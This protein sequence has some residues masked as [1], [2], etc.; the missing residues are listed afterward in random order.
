MEYRFNIN[1]VERKFWYNDIPHRDGGEGTMEELI[2]GKPSTNENPA[3]YINCYRDENKDLY[4]VTS[5]GIK[6]M[7]K[8]AITLT[9]E[10]FLQKAYEDTDNVLIMDEMMR[11]MQKY[12]VGCIRFRMNNNPLEYSGWS[13]DE[14]GRGVQKFFT[15]GCGHKGRGINYKPEWIEYEARAEFNRMPEDNYKLRLYATQN[16]KEHRTYD[17]YTMD[18]NRM[19]IER[20]DYMQLTLGKIGTPN[21]IYGK[22][23]D[24]EYIKSIKDSDS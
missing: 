5:D 6:V 24:S 9:P 16:P 13:V 4:F 19:W 15:S 21:G 18:L 22:Q 14:R 12:G 10:E 23:S 8:D 20:P 2:D 11:T 1:G 17:F 7:C 3:V